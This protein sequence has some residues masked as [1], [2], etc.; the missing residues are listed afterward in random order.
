[1]AQ[2]LQKIVSLC[3]RRGFVYPGSEIYG[4]LANTFDYGPLGVELLRNI[5]N[6]WWQTFVQ[7]RKDIYGL[8]GGILLNPKVWQASGHTQGFVD[9]LLECKECRKRFRKDELEKNFCPECKGKLSGPK[10]FNTM[11]KTFIGPVESKAAVAYLRPETAQAIF[12]N[13]QNIVKTFSPKIPFGIGQIGKAFR[14]EITLGKF[15]FR[16]LEFEQMEIEYFIKKEEWKKYFQEWKK[17][18]EN[19]ALSL[20]I[21]K[22]SLRW[23]AHAKEELSHYSQRT[24]DLEFNFDGEFLELYGFAYRTDFDLSNHAEFSGKDLKYRDPET[25]KEFYPHAVEPS[26]G[27]SRTFLAILFDAYAEE[28]E[29]IVL[30]LDPKIAP[31]KLAVFPLLA[32]KKKLVKKARAVF[33]NLSKK[34]VTAWDNIGNIG[35]RYRRQDEIGTP[36]CLTIDFQTLKDNTVTVRDRDSMKQERIPIN[37]LE[38]YFKKELNG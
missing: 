1:M 29:R 9:I 26:F 35:K 28:K 27:A 13:F 5:K 10:K 6:N 31:Y 24:E 17:L 8:D 19:W 12:I 33:E 20:G 37:K 25:G 23:R 18:I 32:N 36:W 15:I 7:N 30:K 16:T 11:F 3:K 21:K 4:G 34:Y 38:D 22:Q 2:K 14:N